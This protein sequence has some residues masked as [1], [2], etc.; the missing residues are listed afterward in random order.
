MGTG[1]ALPLWP[2]NST[3]KMDVGNNE[4][5]YRRAAYGISPG[6]ELGEGTDS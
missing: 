3:Y 6:P 1:V 4:V 2:P 5:M